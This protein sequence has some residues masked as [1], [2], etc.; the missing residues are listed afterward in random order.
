[1]INKNILN[2]DKYN[3]KAIKWRA[4]NEKKYCL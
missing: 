3:L 4:D 2:W 1:M